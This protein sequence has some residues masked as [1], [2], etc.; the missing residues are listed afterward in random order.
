MISA[1]PCKARA[2]G[3]SFPRRAGNAS[4]NTPLHLRKSCVF[5]KLCDRLF[6]AIAPIIVARAFLDCV[7]HL[8]L[9]LLV[10]VPRLREL[11]LGPSFGPSLG[12]WP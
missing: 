4:R 10:R 2:C 7:L 6:H 12:L 9:A 11:G 3:D 5:V 1:E 8:L